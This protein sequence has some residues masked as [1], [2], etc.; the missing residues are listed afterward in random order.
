MKKVC[1]ILE[2]CICRCE[3]DERAILKKTNVTNC[4]DARL[5]K[6]MDKMKKSYTQSSSC[7]R[8]TDTSM[9][10]YLIRWKMTC[11]KKRSISKDCKQGKYID[12]WLEK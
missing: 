3:N 4:T 9:A 12:G 7:T 1:N 5:S 6:A 2:L 8:R 11:Y 10:I